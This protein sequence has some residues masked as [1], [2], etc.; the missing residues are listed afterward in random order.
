MVPPPPINSTMTRHF[1]PFP[2]PAIAA[3]PIPPPRFETVSLKDV[4]ASD[5]DLTAKA[6]ALRR[7]LE[8]VFGQRITFQGERR[9]PSGTPIVV[10][11]AEVNTIAGEAA[12]LVA[13]TIAGGEVR[14]EL[15]SD[16]VEAGGKAYGLKVDRIG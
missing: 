6:D 13:V 11:I 5:A 1:I 14:G 9:P 3:G 2:R 7:Q 10:G 4:D 8:A 15:K 12:G 16:K